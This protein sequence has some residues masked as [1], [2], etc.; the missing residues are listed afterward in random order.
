MCACVCLFCVCV[1]CDFWAPCCVEQ[2]ECVV[3]ALSARLRVCV[4]CERHAR[5]NES[6][7]ASERERE[8][9]QMR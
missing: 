1:L 2:T 3:C 5:A 8:R 9:R 7:R 6:E 4:R